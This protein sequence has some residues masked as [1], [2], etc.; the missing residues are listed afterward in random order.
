MLKLKKVA[1]FD[2]NSNRMKIIADVE[3]AVKEF[4]EKKIKI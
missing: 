1:A 4:K 3:K 2:P